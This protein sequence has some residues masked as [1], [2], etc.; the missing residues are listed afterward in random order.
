M[1]R[2]VAIGIFGL[3][4]AIAVG[5]PMTAAPTLGA[6]EPMAWRFAHPEAQILAGVDFRRLGETV[7]GRLIRDQFAGAL[8]SA[9]VNQTERLLMSSVVDAGG[10]RSD[11]FVLSGSFS[12]TELRKLAMREG[13]KMASYKGLEIAA[14]AGAGPGEPHLAWING[15]GGGTTVLVG[16]R[17]AIQA[18]AERSKANVDSLASVNALFE[19]ARE[20]APHY[21]IWVSCETVPQGF[22]PKALDTLLAIETGDGT[23]VEGFDLAVQ[24]AQT[25]EVN[26][27][28]W[29]GSQ[30]MAENVLKQ[31]QAPQ[32]GREAFVLSGWLS[33][34][35]AGFDESTLVLRAPLGIGLASQRV[36]PLLAAFALPLETKGVAVT[37]AKMAPSAKAAAAVPAAPAAPPEPPAPPKKMVVRIE[38]LDD[39]TK[40]VP[41][42]KKP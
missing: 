2:R 11:I 12:L 37:P 39:G 18:A 13:A 40:E 4:A 22:G 23:A 3:V 30:A 36:Y 21:P 7:D 24:T 35:K 16:T 20:M 17:P 28:V 31:L 26:M 41:Y 10:Q 9:L 5:Q 32:S 8:G 27:W 29:T 38:G 25:P 6:S 15:A 34:M 1:T 19:R 33:D 14:P 42:E